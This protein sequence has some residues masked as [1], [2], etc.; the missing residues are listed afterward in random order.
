MS[1]KNLYLAR[2]QIQK[3]ISTYSSMIDVCYIVDTKQRVV[4]VT[5]VGFT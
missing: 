3:E 2:H 1:Y 5:L 4:S